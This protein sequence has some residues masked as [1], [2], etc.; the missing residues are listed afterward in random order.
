MKQDVDIQ[1]GQSPMIQLP[2]RTRMR[3]FTFSSR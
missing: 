3:K 2:K 1:I